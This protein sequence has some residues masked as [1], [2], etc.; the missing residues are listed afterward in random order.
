MFILILQ[1]SLITQ[2][3]AISDVYTLSE[4][5]YWSLRLVLHQLP[6]SMQHHHSKAV[7]ASSAEFVGLVAHRTNLPLVTSLKLRCRLYL[8]CF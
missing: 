7:V 1:F 3:T 5:L 8:Y 2:I 4:L 6:G